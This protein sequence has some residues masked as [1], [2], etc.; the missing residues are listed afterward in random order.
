MNLRHLREE[1]SQD[2]PKGI[3]VDVVVPSYRCNNYRI[4][5]RICRHRASVAAYIKFWIV[6]DNPLE[7]H[8]RDVKSLQE[9]LNQE[10]LQNSTNYYK[11]VIHFSEN[12]GASY[13]RNTGYN[14]SAADYMILDDDVIPDG[15]LLD[16]YIGA[17]PRYPDGKVFVGNTDLPPACNIYMRRPLAGVVT[18][19]GLVATE[20]VLKGAYYFDDACRVVNNRGDATSGA[21]WRKL[22]V[23]IGAGSVLSA[24]V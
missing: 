17:I 14:Y 4:L 23:A 13:A 18:T 16:A 7:S 9:R 22:V 20:F 15:N 11:N 19:L 2:C 21:L 12:Q 24:Q 5:E 3:V 10:Q 6:A 1:F 8:V